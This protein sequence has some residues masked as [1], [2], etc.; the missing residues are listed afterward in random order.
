MGGKEAEI[1]EEPMV[2]GAEA[3]WATGNISFVDLVTIIQFF[4]L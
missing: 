4:A 2:V 3:I 1:R